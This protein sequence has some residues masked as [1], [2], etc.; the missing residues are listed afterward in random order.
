MPPIRQDELLFRLLKDINDIRS[1]LRR[2]TANLPLFDIANE[3][4]PAVLAANQDDYVPG[5]YDI[6]RL[7]SS[8]NVSITGIANGKKGRRLQIFNVGSYSITLSHQSAS[9]TASNRFKFVNNS[10]FIIPPD[11]NA[12]IYYDNTSARWVG[13]DMASIYDVS[14][15]S[16][17]A[18]ITADQ[19]NYD[20]GLSEVLRL[21]TNAAHS[22]TGISGGVKGRSLRIFNVGSFNITLPYESTSSS[23]VNRF[24]TPSGENTVLYPKSGVWLYYDSTTQRW[25][26]PDAPTWMGT[27]GKTVIIG[28][29]GAQSI[30]D[31]TDTKLTNLDTVVSDYWGMWNNTTHTLTI[32]ETGVYL[33][34][35]GVQFDEITGGGNYRAVKWVRNGWPNFICP[36]QLPPC[37]TP[38][39]TDISAPLF[40]KFTTGD[41]LEVYVAQDCGVNKDVSVWQM[42]LTRIT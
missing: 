14:N 23:A 41:T 3:N 16:T 36:M 22:I 7:S 10:D 9:S 33:G 31:D 12:L 18:Q 5:N 29:S 21:S 13:G 19:N 6:L 39:A 11:G 24:Y 30:P 27:Y 40:Y 28:S 2:V 15:E 32:P 42:A 26:I 8:L 25:R 1:A 38:V 37:G 35:I 34:A 4:T 17:P 20:I